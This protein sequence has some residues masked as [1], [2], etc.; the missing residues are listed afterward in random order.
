MTNGR[1]VAPRPPKKSC[2]IFFNFAAREDARP[3]SFLFCRQFA[4]FYGAVREEESLFTITYSLFP[5][6][7]WSQVRDSNPRPAHYE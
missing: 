5:T 1:A 2:G 3:P 7:T 4:S 6:C